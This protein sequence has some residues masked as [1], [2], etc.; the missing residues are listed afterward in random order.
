MTGRPVRLNPDTPTPVAPV[1]REHRRTPGPSTV[2][3]SIV[4]ITCP[5]CGEEVT[6]YLWSLNGSGKRCHCGAK[7]D[8]YGITTAARA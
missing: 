5:F 7:H 1:R 2:G 8:G 6:A 4:Y 3:R